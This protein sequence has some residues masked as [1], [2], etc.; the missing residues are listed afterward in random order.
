MAENLE[1]TNGDQVSEKPPVKV[2]PTLFIAV[3]GTGMEIALRVRRRILNYVWGDSENPVRIGNLTEFPLAQFIHFDLNAGAVTE[4]GQAAATDPLANLVKFS[5]EEK[6]IST[7]EMD[8]Y[9]RSDGELNRHSRIASWFPL[10]RKKTLELGIDPSKG[11]GQIRSLSR[12]YFFDKYLA[13]RPMIEGK[14]NA[15]LAGAD[16]S[17]TAKTERLG[18]ALAPASLRVVV[19]ASTAG[20]TGSG[21]FLDMGYLA[22]WLANTRLTGAKVD[23]CLMLPSGYSGRGKSRTEA[24]TYA[25]LMEM[26]ACIGRGLKYVDEGWGGRKHG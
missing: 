14:I 21:S 5:E 17:I 10:T 22:K 3:G 2:Q 9:M 16:N 15:L 18:L 12:L 13:L 4:S 8:K 11:A 19:I 6:L 25:A 1:S 7:L 23:L 24:N 26:E 20:G